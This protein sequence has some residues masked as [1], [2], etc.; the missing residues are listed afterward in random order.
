MKITPY[1]GKFL[2]GSIFT[3]LIGDLIKLIFADAHDH[4][5]YTSYNRACLILII[6]E[7]YENWTHRNFPLYSIIQQ[8]GSTANMYE[9]S[10]CIYLSTEIVL[11]G[12]RAN[13]FDFELKWLLLLADEIL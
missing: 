9:G 11:Q 12:K 5:H 6:Y 8:S 13:C 7:N 2:R 4:A 10:L 3:K 1:S